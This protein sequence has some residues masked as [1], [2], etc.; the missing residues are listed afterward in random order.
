QM[1]MNISNFCRNIWHWVFMFMIGIVIAIIF[2]RFKSTPEGRAKMDSWKMNMPIIGK[3]VRLN[4]F[5]Q[6][7]RTLSTLLVNGVPVLT[8]LKISEDIMPNVV[9]KKAIAR[10]LEEVKDGKS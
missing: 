4:L 7:A 9:V 6:F 1:L 8:A 5:G 2:I 3:A 10:T